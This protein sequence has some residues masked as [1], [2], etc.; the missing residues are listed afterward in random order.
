MGIPGAS[1]SF[2]E[3]CF[4]DTDVKVIRAAI[5]EHT[6]VQAPIFHGGKFLEDGRTPRDY[7]LFDGYHLQIYGGS[8][9]GARARK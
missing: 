8:K 3:R 7:N 2:V 6:E 1:D 9:G 4:M 5:E